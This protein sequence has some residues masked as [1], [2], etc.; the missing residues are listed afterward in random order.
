[1]CALFGHLG[2]VHCPLVQVQPLPA[3]S[4][5][6]YKVSQRYRLVMMK[7][8]NSRGVRASGCA[9]AFGGSHDIG[10]NYLDVGAMMCWN[11]ANLPRAGDY[12]GRGK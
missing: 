6:L 8:N 7:Y 2:Q 11:V 9:G 3:R 10:Q 1:M 12:I 4:H 5:P